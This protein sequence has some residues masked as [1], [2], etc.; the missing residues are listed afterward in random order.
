[1]CRHHSRGHF[2]FYGKSWLPLKNL[3]PAATGRVSKTFFNVRRLM[4]VKSP[5][6]TSVVMKANGLHIRLF[7][8][9][10]P[11]FVLTS[12]L[13]VHLLVIDCYYVSRCHE[14]ALGGHPACSWETVGQPVE[15]CIDISL[16]G[17]RALVV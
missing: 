15:Q 9:V 10:R 16:V 3:S 5:R 1:M 12:F 6:C 8:S 7:L 2:N 13:Q 4:Y 17:W 14:T 11:P